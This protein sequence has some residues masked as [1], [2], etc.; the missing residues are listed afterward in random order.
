MTLIDTEGPIVDMGFSVFWVV[1][2]LTLLTAGLVMAARFGR[3]GKG[4]GL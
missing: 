4:G 1:L 3:W 2:F